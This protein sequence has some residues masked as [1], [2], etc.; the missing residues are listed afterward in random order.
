MVVAV[1]ALLV[2]LTGT[3]IAAQVVPLANRARVADNA[4]KLR[5]MTPAQVARIP[6]PATTLE[7]KTADQ[8]AALPGPATTAAGTVVYKTAT[9]TLEPGVAVDTTT[10]CDQ[11]QKAVGGGFQGPDNNLITTFDSRPSSDGGAWRLRLANFD[12]ENATATLVAVCLK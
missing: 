3:A 12:F 5:G 7:G 8:I 4:K 11:G 2:A 1:A 10:A 6:G 9:R